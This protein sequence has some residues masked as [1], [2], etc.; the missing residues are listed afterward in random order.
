MG[1]FKTV[2]GSELYTIG[3]LNKSLIQGYYYNSNCTLECLDNSSSVFP[4]LL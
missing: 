1:V 3:L 2:A 4:E